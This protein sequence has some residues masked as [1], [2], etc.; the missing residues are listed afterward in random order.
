VL[1]FLRRLAQNAWPLRPLW[2]SL[3]DAFGTSDPGFSVED[4]SL[5]AALADS[6][7]MQALDGLLRERFAGGHKCLVFSQMTK[8]MDLLEAYCRFRKWAYLRLDG[9]TSVADRRDMVRAWQSPGDTHFVFLLSTRAGGLGINL[10]AADTVIFYDNDWNPTQDAQAMDRAHRLGQTKPVSVYR[11]VCGATVE[12]RIL[13]RAQ[14]KQTV[15]ALVM[16]ENTATAAAALAT[17]ASGGAAQTDED[18]GGAPGVAAGGDVFAPEEVFSLLLDDDELAAQLAANQQQRARTSGPDGGSKRRRVIRMADDGETVAGVVDMD[19]AGAA[20]NGADG[21]AAAAGAEQKPAAKKRAPARRLAGAKATQ[22]QSRATPAVQKAALATPAM[23]AA[24]HT[25][26]A[27]VQSGLPSASVPPA[28][29]YQ[30]AALVPA[31][32]PPTAAP[33]VVPSQA[34]AAPLPSSEATQPTQPMK[35]SFKIKLKPQ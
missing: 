30:P 14:Q 5:A 16:A 35:M 19:D 9:S 15:Q 22:M 25:L 7:K 24:T 21:N 31:I 27:P 32:P 20:P 1:P 33:I 17:A 18:G 23:H 28:P 4:Y 12:E 34:A 10:T 2:A 26:A 29:P 6:G 3:R 13:V 11:L 8:M